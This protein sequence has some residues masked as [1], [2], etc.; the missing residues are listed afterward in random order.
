MKPGPIERWNVFGW[1]RVCCSSTKRVRCNMLARATRKDRLPR[2]DPVELAMLVA[3][4]IM[5]TLVA[6][7]L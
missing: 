4:V 3:G 2:F 6:V 5:L 7:A 1:R